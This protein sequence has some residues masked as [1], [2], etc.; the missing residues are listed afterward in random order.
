[1]RGAPPGPAAPPARDRPAQ[2]PADGPIGGALTALDLPLPRARSG[3]VRECFEVGDRLLLVAT[4]RISAFDVVFAR[5]VPGKG[6]VLTG[7]S[8][9]WFDRLDE[10]GGDLPA[11]EHHLLTCDAATIAREAGLTPAA[12]PLLAGRSMLVRGTRPVPIECVVRGFLEGSALAQYRA[13]RSVAGLRLPPGLR[14]A[15]RLRHPLFTPARKALAGHDENVDFDEVVRLVGGELAETLREHSLALYAA[16]ARCLEER[17]LLLADT[18]LEFGLVEEEGG[19]RV[20]L[21]DEVLTPDSSRLWEASAWEPGRAQASFDKQPLRD[22]LD[23]LVERGLWNRQPPAPELS[24]DV[25]SETSARYA[26]AFRR[27][28][29]RPLGAA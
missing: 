23:E 16:A 4:D 22:F 13:G 26:E 27:I 1:M 3:K 8:E 14:R 5:G 18:K 20:L 15:D 10:R 19:S 25:V 7:V 9:H 28:T 12:E 24:D 2:R 17:G 29:G 6:R 21:I 11:L